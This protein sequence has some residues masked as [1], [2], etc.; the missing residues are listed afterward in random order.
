M[1]IL[2]SKHLSAEFPPGENMTLGSYL[3]KLLRVERKMQ[4]ARVPAGTKKK[5]ISGGTEFYETRKE[6]GCAP[7]SV[8]GEM[9]CRALKVQRRWGPGQLMVAVLYREYGSV[10][11]LNTW[12]NNVQFEVLSVPPH[13][14][15]VK[16]T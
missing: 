1:Y 12:V 16:R 6:I 3:D 15:L 11:Y 8:G 9:K 5:K 10:N 7:E 13:N 4:K 2:L 14:P